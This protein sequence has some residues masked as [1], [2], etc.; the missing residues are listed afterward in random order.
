MCHCLYCVCVIM[1]VETSSVEVFD[2]KSEVL[3]PCIDVIS[4]DEL[5][6]TDIEHRGDFPENSL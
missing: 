1:W 2:R 5:F 6:W 4:V 3:V